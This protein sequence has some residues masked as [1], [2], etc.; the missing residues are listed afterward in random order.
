MTSTSRGRRVRGFFGAVGLPTG[1]YAVSAGF[2]E[3]A[4][5]RGQQLVR[6]A[7]EIA[8][9]NLNGH[10]AQGKSYSVYSAFAWL[11]RTVGGSVRISE[12]AMGT[13]FDINPP[14]N[15]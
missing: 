8:A 3:L 7:L 9:A 6:R 1:T 15:P 12:H 14:D 5:I 11:W 10:L 2:G 13:A 4:E